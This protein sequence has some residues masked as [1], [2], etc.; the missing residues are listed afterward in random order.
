MERVK[1]RERLASSV[2]TDGIGNDILK[3][4]A[5]ATGALVV[6]VV[7]AWALSCVV[8]AVVEAGGPLALFNAW[9]GAISGV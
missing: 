5:V 4:S 8:A 3:G 2:V 1:T 7:G 6:G 9:I